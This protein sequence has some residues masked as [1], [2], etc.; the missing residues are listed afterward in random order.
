ML[1]PHH[2]SVLYHC[3]YISESGFKGLIEKEKVLQ[4]KKLTCSRISLHS[5]MGK[6]WL[7]ITSVAFFQ[8]FLINMNVQ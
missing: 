4:M 5:V 6:Q 1:S 8:I 7:V 3:Y 2:R